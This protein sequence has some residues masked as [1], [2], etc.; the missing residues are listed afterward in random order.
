MLKKQHLA[1][2]IAASL[3]AGG[4]QALETSI[5]LKN[6]T[7]SM[8]KDG[9]RNGEKTFKAD[10][11]GEGK[12]VYKFE[13]T[14][15][16]FLND[17]L[18]NGNS[19]HGELKF[20]RDNK[21]VDGYQGHMNMSQQ[22]YLR[23]LY[24]DTTAGD[25][26]VRIGKQ[27]VVWGT[28][29]GIK[30]LD[31]MNPTDWREF[32]QNTMAEA[33]IPTW[34]INAE[35]YLDNGANIQ[36][37]VGIAEK[38]V[39]A[40]L[41]GSG[42]QGAPFVM[43]GVDSITGKVNGFLH[44][45]PALAKVAKSFDLMAAS[46]GFATTSSTTSTSLTPFTSMTVDGFGGNNNSTTGA[47]YVVGDYATQDVSAMGISAGD[48]VQLG[49]MLANGQTVTFT[50]AALQSYGIYGP[51]NWYSSGAGQTFTYAYATG[52][53]SHAS[54][55]GSSVAYASATSGTA[56]LYG[57]AQ[58]GTSIN[59]YAG[60]NNEVTNLVDTTWGIDIPDSAFEY[61][62]NATFATFNTFAGMTTRYESDDAD[63]KK[64][65][66]GLRFKNTTANGLNYSFNYAWRPD[67]NP[68]IDLSYRDRSS[69][70]T[71]S[72]VYVSGGNA[73]TG[74]PVN[75]SGVIQGDVITAEQL[76]TVIN[77]RTFAQASAA[78]TTMGDYT[79]AYYLAGGAT[80]AVTV[81]L[82]DSNNNYY[83]AKAWDGTSNPNDY[84]DVEMLFSEKTNRV[85]NIG[86]SFDFAID[87]GDNP[88]VVRG[89]ALYTRG[90]MQPVV[91][92]HILATGDLANSL[93]MKETDTFKYVIGLDTTVMTDMMMSGQFIQ[94]R[95]LDYVDKPKTCTT[96]NGRTFDCGTYTG[97]MAVLGMDNQMQ[98][99]K[100]NKEFYSLFLSKPFGESGEGRWNN[101]FMFEEGGGKWN[102]FDVEYGITD[103]LIGT[104]EYNK[105]FGDNNTMFGQFENNSN[106]QLGV[107]Y[108]LQ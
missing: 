85:H 94:F 66:L 79:M 67:S 54:A 55:G 107:K 30:L 9:L 108:L 77:A 105:Y 75:S 74:L 2:A 29:D 76:P 11:T 31:M 22:D 5:V 89:E 83:G 43:K 106:V 58:N 33:R 35:K 48:F 50:S 98:K 38:N 64:G 42:D 65:Q 63:K 51:S 88:V 6:E 97:D 28:A 16:F 80:N 23:E 53:S 41:N 104:F 46:G 81:L 15:Q 72:V 93:T 78:A 59:N 7:A 87:T 26:D 37:I 91:N 12:G 57:T 70:E 18:G 36:A 14:A 52:G 102:R 49:T 90:E 25:W 56:L 13:N 40:G 4:S 84:N 60:A 19:W 86:G 3:I 99:A 21:A 34:M 82:K 45:T 100:E 44:V 24:L 1:L 32:N 103:Q 69:G 95:N 92:R 17:D 73:Q 39:I 27:Q 96:Q 47:Y 61:M 8:V 68:Y 20:T 62:P 71:L 101:I 10:T